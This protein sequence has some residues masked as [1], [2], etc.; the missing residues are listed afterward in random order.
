[1]INK[2]DHPPTKGDTNCH[3]MAPK[4]KNTDESHQTVPKS[5]P[6]SAPNNKNC[7]KAPVAKQTKEDHTGHPNQVKQP[8][9]NSQAEATT[10]PRP[11]EI[12]SLHINVVQMPTYDAYTGNLNV[13]ALFD[14]GA[15]LSC[16]S[17]QCYDRIHQK[18]PDQIIDANAGPPVVITSVSND[19]LTNLG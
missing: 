2:Q 12:L 3:Y 10:P 18:E 6:K 13:R 4:P 1:M 7:Q 11:M 16:I 9:K 8:L 19:D 15:T 17:K 5:A 14:S